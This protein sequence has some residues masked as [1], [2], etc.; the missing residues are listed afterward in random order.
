MVTKEVAQIQVLQMYSYGE[1]EPLGALSLPSILRQN[2][3]DV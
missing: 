1:I 2:A 3:S